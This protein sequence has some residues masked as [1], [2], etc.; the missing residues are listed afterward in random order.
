MSGTITKTGKVQLVNGSQK[1]TLR[2]PGTKTITQTGQGVHATTWNVGT[3][4]E[5]MPTGEI[6]TLGRFYL[7]NLDTTNYVDIGVDSGGSMVGC[8]RLMPG[9]E[10]EFRSKPGA[11]WKGQAHTAACKVDIK[12]CED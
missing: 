5:A 7:T 8:I 10:H 6:S 3:S 1:T 4:E 2:E 11:T 9:E 12:I